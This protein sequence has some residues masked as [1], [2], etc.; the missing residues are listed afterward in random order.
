M[1][2]EMISA[3][4]TLIEKIKSDYYDYT[5]RHG[6][7]E[8]TEIN[9]S[10]IEEFNEGLGYTVGK[11]YI[12]ITVRNGGSVWGFVVAGEDKK[13]DEGDILKAAGWSTPARNKARGNILDG[14]F[15]WI[16]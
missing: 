8:L 13:F 9:K 14:D 5:S 1:K 12:K 11:K 7:H 3:V 16:R 2:Y 15:T 4:E 6:T 10:M